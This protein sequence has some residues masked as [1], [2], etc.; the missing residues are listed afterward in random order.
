MCSGQCSFLDTTDNA[1]D[2]LDSALHVHSIALYNMDYSVQPKGL[3]HTGNAGKKWFY[4]KIV[5]LWRDVTLSCT[6]FFIGYHALFFFSFESTAVAIS[7]I[8]F[9]MQCI[10]LL[11]PFCALCCYLSRSLRG[12]D[13]SLPLGPMTQYAYDT[14]FR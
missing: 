5:A 10:S 11:V 4:F 8:T 2:G 1:Y 12:F 6:P 3:N 7:R 13:I 14:L 9:A